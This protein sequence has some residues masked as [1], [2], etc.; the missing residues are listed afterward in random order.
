MNRLVSMSQ[1]AQLFGFSGSAHEV[2]RKARRRLRAIAENDP[3]FS[4]F[5]PEGAHGWHTTIADLRRVIPELFRHES[6]TADVVLEAIEDISEKLD[7]LGARV[8][9]VERVQFVNQ[10]ERPKQA[11]IGHGP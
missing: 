11:Q 4:F 6:D 7:R 1:A 3:T 9:R 5:K 8:A 10:Q 2:A